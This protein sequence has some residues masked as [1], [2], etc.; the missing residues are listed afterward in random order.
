[1]IGSTHSNGCHADLTLAFNT[2]GAGGYTW[3][4]GNYMPFAGNSNFTTPAT[5][6]DSNEA[7]GSHVA[8]LTGAQTSDILT[9]TFTG[10]KISDDSVRTAGHVETLVIPALTPANT[11]YQTDA[12]WLGT[13]TI[14]RVS[15]TAVACNYMLIEYWDNTDV[16]FTLSAFEANWVGGANDT[17]SNVEIFHYKQTGWTYNAGGPVMPTAIHSMTADFSPEIAIRNQKNG[18]YEKKGLS[19]RIQ[20]SKKEGLM[21]KITSGAPNVFR[22]GSVQIRRA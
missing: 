20:G 9:I 10:T 22:Q 12:H 17:S 7:H 4:A 2:I 15:G 18:R 13:V 21:I 3:L 11:F 8:I 1:M 19:Q 16:D 5:I 6:G 14:A